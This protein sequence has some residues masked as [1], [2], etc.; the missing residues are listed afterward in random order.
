MTVPQNFNFILIIV[1]GI[2]FADQGEGCPIL[3]RCH[4][5]VLPEKP[6]EMGNIRITDA[7]RDLHD[8]HIRSL[9]QGLSL[10]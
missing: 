6:V 3:D 1:D 4:V 10:T 9:K 8:G 2:I 5:A 7:F